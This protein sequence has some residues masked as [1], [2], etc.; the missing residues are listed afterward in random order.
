MESESE[1]QQLVCIY[2]PEEVFEVVPGEEEPVGLRVYRKLCGDE[3]ICHPS[4]VEKLRIK[5][6]GIDREYKTYLYTVTTPDG[7][8]TPP[9]R[10]KD[11]S[12]KFHLFPSSILAPPRN[13]HTLTRGHRAGY[14][15]ERIIDSDEDVNEKS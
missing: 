14:T 12:Y 1:T 11:I 7:I 10:A 5:L 2:H 4:E 9:M 3:Y 13:K 8:K 15:L 6:L